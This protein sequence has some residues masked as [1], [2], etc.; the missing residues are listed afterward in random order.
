LSQSGYDPRNTV[1]AARMA[2]ESWPDRVPRQVRAQGK[3]GVDAPAVCVQQKARGSHHRRSRLA[4]L[5]LR[6]GLTAYSMFSPE[7]GFVVSVAGAM[8][9]HCRRLDNQ[10]RDVRTAWLCRTLQVSFVLS[11]LPRPSH[12]AP[13]VRDDRDTPL[14]WARNVVDSASDFSRRSIARS[15]AN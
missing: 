10:H 1:L 11:I 12:P 8:R 3:P 14:M 4:R 6:G 13:N 5:S 15:A 9:K 7:T 2:S